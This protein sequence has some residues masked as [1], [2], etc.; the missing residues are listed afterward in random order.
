MSAQNTIDDKQSRRRRRRRS[1]PEEDVEE[2]AEE[3]VEEARGLTEGKGRITPG[4][5]NQPEAE[6][7]GNFI[8]RPLNSIVEYFQGVQSEMGKV[9]WP[10][11]EETIRLA[12]IVLTT[13]VVC[14]IV[15]GIIGLLFTELFRL[16]L[17]LPVLFIILFAAIIGIAI[18][19]F[20][21]SRGPA[22]SY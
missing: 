8:T 17:D 21:R 14:A 16:G 9:A 3:V 12:V 4:R 5:R 11:R 13:L 18:Y 2:E 6:S 1:A 15:L 10:S 20:W 19:S 22:S 7:E